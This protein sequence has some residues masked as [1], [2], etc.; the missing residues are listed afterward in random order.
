MA[1]QFFDFHTAQLVLTLPFSTSITQLLLNRTNNLLAVVCDDF[2]VR[3][4]DIDSKRVVREL[5]DFQGQVLDVV[6]PLATR[7]LPLT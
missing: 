2:T 5:S 1:A 3:I 6:C 7:I 4:I